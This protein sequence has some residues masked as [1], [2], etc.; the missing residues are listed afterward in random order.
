MAEDLGD[1]TEAPTGRRLSDARNEGRIAKSQDLAAAIDLFGAFVLLLMFGAGVGKVMATIVRQGLESKG[2]LRVDDVMDLV[3][4]VGLQT[5][6]AVAPMLAFLCVIAAAGHISQFGLVLST[7]VLTP[8]FSRLNPAAGLGRLFSKRG[9]AKTVVNSGKLAVV[10]AVGVLYLR[11]SVYKLT[12]LPMFT[13]AAAWAIIGKLALQLAAW[14]FTIMV[15]MGLIDFLYQKWQHHQDLRMTKEEVK[16]ER[17]SMEGDPQIKGRRLRMARQIA[18][19]RINSAVPK[20]D[21]VVTNPTHFSVAIRYDQRTMSAP[22]VVAKG[23]D[24]MAMRIREVARHHRVP[25]I[26]RPPLARALYASV[27]VGGEIRPEFY[28]AVAEL[29]AFV[30]RLDRRAADENEIRT[31]SPVVNNAQPAAA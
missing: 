31:L 15:I 5:A 2:A 27:P 19:Q 26:E 29:L 24:E 16:D 9:L 14:L 18:M 7:S 4:L 3:R 11:A 1:K 6:V 10:S 21:V 17:R 25:V 8:N 23:A 13:A 28:E 22:K 12:A 20:A 30:Y